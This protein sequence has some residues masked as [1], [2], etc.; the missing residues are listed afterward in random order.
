[1]LLEEVMRNWSFPSS[2]AALAW[3]GNRLLILASLRGHN[4]SLVERLFCPLWGHR[5]DRRR[6]RP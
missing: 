6:A 4:C 2:I 1:M 3:T 5:P